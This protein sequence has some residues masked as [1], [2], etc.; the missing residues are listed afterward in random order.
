[1][2]KYTPECVSYQYKNNGL[3]MLCLLPV[4][5]MRHT[6]ACMPFIK[7]QTFHLVPSEKPLIF[8]AHHGGTKLISLME[9]QGLPALP[10]CR[11]QPCTKAASWCSKGNHAKSREM[12]TSKTGK[13]GHAKVGPA[14]SFFSF[15]DKI[16]CVPV[17]FVTFLNRK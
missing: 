5:K 15:T 16:I 6:P 3:V 7:K 17:H 2:A 11:V 4:F 8:P 13:H 9:M 1:M 10:L 12:A 14:K